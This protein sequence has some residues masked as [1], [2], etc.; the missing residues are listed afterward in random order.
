MSCSDETPLNRIEIEASDAIT[1]SIHVI[2]VSDTKIEFEYKLSDLKKIMKS[3]D[4]RL[5]INH[6][7]FEVVARESVLSNPTGEHLDIDQ[8]I[9]QPIIEGDESINSFSLPILCYAG[10]TVWGDE[11]FVTHPDNQERIILERGPRGGSINSSVRTRVLGT[12]WMTA[13]GEVREVINGNNTFITG[14]IETKRKSC[15]EDDL[16]GTGRSSYS[17]SATDRGTFA[18]AIVNCDD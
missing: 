16:R 9:I 17:R 11:P 18:Y 5:T 10:V 14:A 3:P 15:G 2:S 12:K 6:E 7:A 13:W 1:S 4:R 8:V